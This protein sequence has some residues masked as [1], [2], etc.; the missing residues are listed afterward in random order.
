MVPE[1]GTI[2]PTK[3]GQVLKLVKIDNVHL[4]LFAIGSGTGD[5]F[6]TRPASS[7]RSGACPL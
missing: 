4:P 7:G 5:T 1:F 6:D 3:L 2:D